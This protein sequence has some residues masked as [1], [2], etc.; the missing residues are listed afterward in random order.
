MIAKETRLE[1]GPYEVKVW[2]FNLLLVEVI[3][4]AGLALPWVWVLAARLLGAHAPWVD[5]AWKGLGFFLLGL[6]LYPVIRVQTRNTRGHE[7]SFSRW[8]AGDL[9]GSAVGTVLY[10]LL[11]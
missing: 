10:L 7:P 1:T 4:L 2:E 3:A 9:I 8:I 11:R 6:A 5:A